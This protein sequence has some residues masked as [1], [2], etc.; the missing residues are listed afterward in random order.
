M[1]EKNKPYRDKLKAVRHWFGLT[2]QEVADRLGFHDVKEYGR[3]ET[4]EKRLT[5]ELLDE[6]AGVFDMSLLELLSINER[7]L[8]GQGGDHARVDGSTAPHK[9][10]GRAIALANERI[11]HLEGEVE[12]LRKLLE[13]R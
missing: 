2:Q 8:P 9:D 3:L 7:T 11:K 1:G 13:R 12:F 6:I 4:G 5:L 10:I